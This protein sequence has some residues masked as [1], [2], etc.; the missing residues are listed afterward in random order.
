LYGEVDFII[1]NQVD[2]IVLMPSICHVSRGKKDGNFSTKILPMSEAS[3]KAKA[4]FLL[5]KRIECC[6]VYELIDQRNESKSIMKYHQVFIA[7]RVFAIPLTKKYTVSAVMF[8]TR[9]GQFT[10]SEDD[11]RRLEKSILQ[12]YLVNNT[13]SSEYA[14]RDRMLSLE[15]TFYPGKQ[16]NIKVILKKTTKY[17]NKF[18]VLF[19]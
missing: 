19:E 11:M 18:P 13:F 16:A 1:R 12:K 6:L 15:A 2:D 10:G 5:A 9:S 4:L 7:V 17:A 14:I 8:M 3:M